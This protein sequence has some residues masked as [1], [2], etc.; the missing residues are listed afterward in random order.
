MSAVLG[1]EL[2]VPSEF[3][4][5]V[6]LYKKPF[7]GRMF[8]NDRLSCCLISAQANR[9]RTLE[10]IEQ[11]CLINIT[12]INVSSLY[13]AESKGEDNGLYTKDTM[14]WWR[15]KGWDVA[16]GEVSTVKA[17]GCWRKFFPPAPIGGQHLDIFAYAEM[18]SIDELR[19]A[20]YYLHGA[21]ICVRMTVR[22]F[23]QFNAG[24]PWSLTGNTTDYVSGHAVDMPHFLSDDSLECWTWGKRQI[25]TADWYRQRVYDTV[26]IVDNRNNFK[27][28]NPTDYDKLNAILQGIVNN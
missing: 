6:S 21:I 15:Q 26:G 17:R 23:Q 3:D 8:C 25:M 5:E 28:N 10:Y 12:D 18:D 27:C 22:D 1:K 4:A 9:T 2:F 20:I 11:G 14:D 19:Q 7:P 16:G 24:E 13:K